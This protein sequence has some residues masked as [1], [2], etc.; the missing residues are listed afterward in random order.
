MVLGVGVLHIQVGGGGQLAAVGCGGGD[1]TCVHQCHAGH[2]T[3]ARLGALAVGEVA[4]GVADGELAVCRAVACAEAGA[5]EALTYDGAGV[6]K[7]A[8]TAILV[9]L[10]QCGH[11]AGVDAQ[12]ED[13]VAAALAAQDV[14][15]ST[16]VVEGAAGAAS[17]LALVHPDSAVVELAVEV[18]LSA[19]D[20]LV[21]LFLHSVEDVGGVGLQLVDGVGV[22]GVHGHCDGGL[23]GVEVDV[24]AAV[25]VSH[26]G[27]SQLLVSLGTAMDHEVALGL[28]VGHPDG[29]PAGGLG[30]H[31]VDGV[32]ELDGQICHAGADELHDLVLDV[33]VLVDSAADA[34]GHVVGAD[35]C[36]GLAGQID[37]DDL[38]TGEVIGAAHQLLCQLA[39]ALA[40]SHG[41][42]SAVTSVGVGAEDHLAAACHGLTVVAVDVCHVGRDVDAAVLVGSG[43]GELVVVLIDGAADSAEAVVAV[44]Q[45]VGQGE[46]LHAGSAGRL[47]DADI[48]D[49]VA[50]HGVELQTKLVHVVALVVS[51]QDAV[52]HG[53][54]GGLFFGGGDAGLLSCLFGAGA[55]GLAVNEV[56]AVVIQFEHNVCFLSRTLFFIFMAFP[57][58]RPSFWHYDTAVWLFCK[59]FDFD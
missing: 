11:G 49:V 24:D 56:D 4:G 29:R 35:A 54:L 9:Q 44:G 46:S 32:A 53:T 31:D 59:I 18:H 17:D 8:C 21:G 34:Q 7:V 45:D 12:S 51:L 38:R 55:D 33:A 27:R 36:A 20:L 16:D 50:G 43:E 10:G 22:G 19:L 3:L 28:L 14:S 48:S 42:Q 2:L 52:G 13:T 15:S 30:G 47:D 5:A 23:D 41:T 1:G 58:G 37:G 26:I 39:A 40:D 6:D 57:G 25:V